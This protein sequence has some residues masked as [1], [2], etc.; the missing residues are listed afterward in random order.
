MKILNPSSTCSNASDKQLAL[1]MTQVNDLQ[2]DLAILTKEVKDFG[3]S[4][5]SA[6]GNITKLTSD[7]IEANKVK[8]TKADIDDL[9][10]KLVETGYKTLPTVEANACIG[11]YDGNVELDIVA[12]AEATVQTIKFK[13]VNDTVIAMSDSNALVDSIALYN[14]QGTYYVEAHNNYGKPITFNIHSKGDRYNS[15]AEIPAKYDTKKDVAIKRAITLAGDVV[16]DNASELTFTDVIFNNI[17]LLNSMKV[18]DYVLRANYEVMEQ[19]DEFTQVELHEG[20]ISFNDGACQLTFKDGKL[21]KAVTDKN[22]SVVE[23]G[24]GIYIKNADT[25]PFDLKVDYSFS[26]DEPKITPN[27][28]DLPNA[29]VLCKEGRTYFNVLSFGEIESEGILLNKEVPIESKGIK[30][31]RL[32]IR[33]GV[34]ILKFADN[35]TGE[36]LA[37]ATITK[38]TST[39]ASTMINYSQKQLGLLLKFKENEGGDILIETAIENAKLYYT[40]TGVKG[41]ALEVNVDTVSTA[42]MKL[43]H[44]VIKQQHV[45]ILGDN[46]LE[47]GLIIDGELKAAL[48]PLPGTSSFEDLVISHDLTVNNDTHLLGNTDA[49]A[50]TATDLTIANNTELNNVTITGT[51]DTGTAKMTDLTI[52]NLEVK[53]DAHVG[54]MAT[55]DGDVF[56]TGTSTLSA[57]DIMGDLNISGNIIQSGKPYETHAEQMFVKNNDLILRDEAEA[58]LGQNETS[59]LS[60]YNYDGTKESMHL[61]VDNKGEARLGRIG[62]LEPLLTREEEANM[63]NNSPIVWSTDGRKAKTITVP[64]NSEGKVLVYNGPDAEPSFEKYSVS[65]SW[66]GTKAEFDAAKVVEDPEAKNYIQD[67][68]VI[69]ITDDQ[70]DCMNVSNAARLGDLNPITSDAVA[71]LIQ[72]VFDN[73]HPLYST[74]IQADAGDTHNPNT[75]FN[76]DMIKSK[77][78]L[79]NDPDHEYLYSVS[80]PEEIGYLRN[81]S[82][83]Q[84][85]HIY[86]MVGGNGSGVAAG[87]NWPREYSAT[88]GV[89]QVFNE[90]GKAIPNTVYKSGAKVQPNSR[91][92]G[93]WER[94]E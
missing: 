82:L 71:K 57:T 33:D 84:H 54:G 63:Q 78:Q 88:S 45:V 13:A 15:T 34:V 94:V 5:N 59:G 29:I 91:A 21:I 69:N 38:N 28:I 44:E 75:L 3:S 16:Y 18:E 81:E 39:N 90:E 40:S 46:S 74:Y 87:G 9:K 80:T 27:I 60:I 17:E 89:T 51:F 52:D 49:K 36:V 56:V 8:I 10:V 67:G 7:A 76:N 48:I 22:F 77:W 31:I 86:Q 42:P 83:P 92:I 85:T 53:Q 93:I 61:S 26:I 47:Y 2:Q 73:E 14:Y 79:V 1:L 65:A 70:S 66:S 12:T 58:G 62:K 32:T 68:A 43:S 4:F 19:V 20:F 23:Q 30:D 55:V 72:T 25:Y 41:K 35:V 24:I 37:S 50:I 6:S 11:K 64:V